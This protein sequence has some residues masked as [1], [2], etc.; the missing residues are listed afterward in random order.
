[1]T[2]T[3]W[4]HGWYVLGDSVLVGTMAHCAGC[5]REMG[6]ATV[7]FSETMPD[8]DPDWPFEKDNCPVCYWREKWHEDTA[9]REAARLRRLDPNRLPE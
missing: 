4:L 7:V 8:K 1:M 3:R 2:D 5:G 9:L 6:L